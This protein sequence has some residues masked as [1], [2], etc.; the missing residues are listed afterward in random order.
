MKYIYSIITG[1]LIVYVAHGQQWNEQWSVVKTYS[2]ENINEVSMPIGGIGTGTVGISGKG[3]LQD[4]EIMN[5]G[6][7]G[8]LPAFRFSKPAT[9][10][11]PFFAIRYAQEGQVPRIK[12]LQGSIDQKKYIGDWGAEE[13]N[14]GFPRFKETTFAAAYP[15]AQVS[16]KNDN[17]PFEVRLEA[18]NPMIPGDEANS[19]IPVAVLRYVVKNTSNEPLDISVAGMVPNFIGYDGW[20]GSPEGNFNIYKEVN[21]IRGLYMQSKDVPKDDH[22]YGTMALT[23]VSSGEVSYRTAWGQEI[24][25]WNFREF[26]DDFLND[27]NLVDHSNSNGKVKTPP[28]TLSLKQTLAPNETKAFTF[29]LTWRFPNRKAWETGV[30]GHWC[31]GDGSHMGNHYCT[32]YKDAWDVAEQVTNKLNYLEDETVKYVKALVDSDIPEILVE[33]GLFNASIMR[34]Q[35]LFVTE[36][37]RPFGWEGTGSIGGTVI[38]EQKTAGWGFGSLTHVWNYESTVP[39]LYGD[40]AKRF[41]E[42]EFMHMMRKNGAQS[43]R[44]GLPLATNAT[45]MRSEAADGQMGT[46]VKMYREWNMSGDDDMLK[47]LWPNIKKSLAFAWTGY[48]DANKDGVMEG[49]QHNTADVNYEGPNPQM[50]SWYLAALKAGGKMAKH[51]GD[52][53]FA[54]ECN[55]LFESGSKWVDANLFNKEFYEHHITPGKSKVAQIGRGCLADQL[56]GQYLA[57][58]AGL[59]YVLDENNIKTTLNSVMKYNF[60]ENFHDHYTSFRTYAIGDEKGLQIL[61]YPIEGALLDSPTPYYT[62]VWSGVEYSTAAHMI[63]EGQIKN[64]LKIFEAV[65]GRY[66]GSNRNPFDEIEYGHRYARSMAA[67]SGILAYTGFEYSAVERTMKFKDQKGKF[68]WSN[69]YQYGTVEISGSE[70]EKKVKLTVLK[71][72]IQLNCF[73]LKGDTLRKYKKKLEIKEGESI[74]ILL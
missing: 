43:H 57:H 4:W 56:V 22:S 3:A 49:S 23:T 54:K 66:N 46:I 32:V 12:A 68:F 39:F 38:G 18:F 50:A 61:T 31:Q 2:G 14:S 17:L 33:A 10:M 62:E 26:Y 5:R 34:S 55:T 19:S 37:G 72:D 73:T 47:Y 65:R 27:G 67:W 69:G 74:K 20:S 53:K 13:V 21:G 30:P 6:A 48:W 63:Y 59:G 15:L 35:T 52:K 9:A 44:V 45:K 64:G 1:F 60:K 29:M 40:I 51:V 16:F 7:M 28:A 11:G 8:F 70:I 25:N 36:D 42:V 24:W 41:R 71:G 58:T